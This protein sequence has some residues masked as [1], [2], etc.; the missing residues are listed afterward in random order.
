MTDARDTPDGDRIVDLYTCARLDGDLAM[1]TAI[2]EAVI[3][4]DKANPD[5]PPLMDRIH[6]AADRTPPRAFKA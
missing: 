3:D 6:E 5:E 1:T 4:H 2:L